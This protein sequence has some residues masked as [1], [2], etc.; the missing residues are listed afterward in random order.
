MES[1]IKFQVLPG[2]D[3]ETIQVIAAFSAGASGE[4]V[5]AIFPIMPRD[6]R[7]LL[8]ESVKLWRKES[9]RFVDEQINNLQKQR[10]AVLV[11]TA[12]TYKAARALINI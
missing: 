12:D 7:I 2:M 3:T 6:Q 4:E 10:K 9:I 5:A 1:P 8:F 11:A